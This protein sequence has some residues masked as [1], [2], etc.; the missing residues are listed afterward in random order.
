MG[1]GGKGR[2]GQGLAAYV[3]ALLRGPTFGQ[4]VKARWSM[5]WSAQYWTV[6][7]E[8]VRWYRGARMWEVKV[9]SRGVA[10]RLMGVLPGGAVA[11]SSASVGRSKGTRRA[12]PACARQPA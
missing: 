3:V 12:M 10:I 11:A 6:D 8:A 9:A 5:T 4:P 1:E 2:G 7:T